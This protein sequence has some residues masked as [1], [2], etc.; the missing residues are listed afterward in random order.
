MGYSHRF[1]STIE[2]LP[3]EL[4]I[5]ECGT[6]DR[7]YKYIVDGCRVNRALYEL[8]SQIRHTPSLRHLRFG[9][10]HQRVVVRNMVVVYDP[11]EVYT[12]GWL[13][14]GDFSR[15][16]GDAKYMV[17]SP[18]IVNNKYSYWSEQY[19]QKLTNNKD[20]ALTLVKQFLRPYTDQAIADAT[21]DSFSAH[22]SETVDE[23]SSLVSSK[24]NTLKD[25][26]SK[27]LRESEILNILSAVLEGT[28]IPEPSA[29]LRSEFNDYAK[30]YNEFQSTVDGIQ[31]RPT[32]VFT[33]R[34]SSGGIGYKVIAADN[35]F[36]QSKIRRSRVAESLR[37]SI[38]NGTPKIYDQST[39]P[40]S[41]MGKLAAI[42]MLDD[43]TYVEGTG[44]KVDERLI[45]VMAEDSDNE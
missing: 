27:G 26:V 9:S 15:N 7:E 28:R 10:T 20:K 5:D 22:L 24:L 44:F 30:V 34:N 35:V 1:V 8:C 4:R 18:N 39:I 41:I 23:S 17:R 2:Q 40:K 45:Y 3:Q 16:G 19:H 33:T 36:L 29:N 12:F 13:G 31:Y 21:V 6:D 42:S 32:L 38:H 14:Y 37:N 25:E 43:N 11:T